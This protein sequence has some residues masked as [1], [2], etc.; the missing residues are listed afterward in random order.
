MTT[1]SPIPPSSPQP[2]LPPSRSAREAAGAS[3]G[4]LTR[5]KAVC[6]GS[7]AV[8]NGFQVDVAPMYLPDHSNPEARRWVFGYR[9]RVSNRSDRAA[10]LI[11]RRWWIVNADGEAEE[12]RGE[13]VV[14][15][16]PRMGPGESF[17]YSS[18]CPLDTPWG[19]MEGE[20]TMRGEDG[21]PF[22]VAVGRFIFVAPVG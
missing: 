15:E 19:T 12:V 7:V 10:T 4:E 21:E 20:Y 18:F 13:G 5:P 2:P 14:G 3:A 17:T 16:Q 1:P 6:K 22:K 8:T 9:I 11:S